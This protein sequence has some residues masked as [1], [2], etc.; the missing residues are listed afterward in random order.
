MSARRILIHLLTLVFAMPALAAAAD[1]WPTRPIRLVVP[2]PPGGSSD[3]ASRLFSQKLTERLGQ[4]IVVDN[5]GSAGGVVG[6]D[7]L[8]RS[9]IGRAHV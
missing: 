8:A 6:A 7:L 3:V 1:T 2:Y 9:E 4:Q 5:R